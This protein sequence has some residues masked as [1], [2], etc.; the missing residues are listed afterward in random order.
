MRVIIKISPRHFAKQRQIRLRVRYVGD[1]KPSNF[2][3]KSWIIFL[4]LFFFMEKTWVQNMKLL[5]FSFRKPLRAWKRKI[6]KNNNWTGIIKF[7]SQ[8]IFCLFE[9]LAILITICCAFSK[10]KLKRLF[11]SS[12]SWPEDKIFFPTS[13]WK[14]FF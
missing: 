5:K 9:L 1:F 4:F 3:H 12:L 7:R 8:K 6:G 11:P 14:L 2:A 13:T 10:K